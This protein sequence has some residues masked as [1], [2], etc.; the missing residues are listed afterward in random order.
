M[1]LATL[2]LHPWEPLP[3]LGEFQRELI[4]HFASLSGRPQ[5]FPLL[6]LCSDSSEAVITAELPGVDPSH[7]EITLTKG[8]LTIRGS[9]EN[10]A[11]GGENSVCHLKERPSGDFARSIRLPFETEESAISAQYQNGILTIRLP[12]AA[13]SKPRTIPVSSN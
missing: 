1:K 9:F 13:A 3:A 6:N 7:L 10:L 2:S 11:P 8:H 5:R 4:R 12:R